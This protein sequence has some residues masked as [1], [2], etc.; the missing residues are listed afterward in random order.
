MAAAKK[1]RRYRGW[2]NA[3]MVAA[4][5]I[6]FPRFLNFRKRTSIFSSVHNLQSAFSSRAFFLSS[7]TSSL[8]LEDYCEFLAVVLGGY[9]RFV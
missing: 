4:R 8:L 2:K 3:K 7:R 5:K 1:L 6:E 9:N